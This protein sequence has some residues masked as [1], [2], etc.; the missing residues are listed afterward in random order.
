MSQTL[1][2]ILDY[3]LNL[4]T[5][6]VINLGFH[7]PLEI[8]NQSN[9]FLQEYFFDSDN[10]LDNN[11]DEAELPEELWESM[12]CNIFDGINI[13]HMQSF[14]GEGKGDDYYTIYKFTKESTGEEEYVKFDGWY[15]SYQGA[16]Y[17]RYFFVQP[18]QRLVTFYS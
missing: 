9:G 16:S 13:A 1:K 14:G 7:I 8:H 11:I 3:T 5:Q 6:D 17:S 4:S 18:S 15:M 12:M 10:F 2:Q